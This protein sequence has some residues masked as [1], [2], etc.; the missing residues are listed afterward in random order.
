[1]KNL[2]EETLGMARST[3]LSVNDVAELAEV[4]SRW[5]RLVLNGQIS[6]PSVRRVQRVHDALHQHESGGRS[7]AR[8][9]A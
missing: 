4:G 8:D 3:D 2:L 9:A 5:L 6:D 1:M 7:G